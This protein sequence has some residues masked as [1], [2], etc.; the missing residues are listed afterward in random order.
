MMKKNTKHNS[1]FVILFAVTLAALLLSIALGVGTIAEKEVRF[2]TSAA[3][4]NHAFFAADTGIECALDNNKSGDIAFT[5]G[6]PGTISCLGGSIPLEGSSS[7][8]SFVLPGL[9]ATN[10]CA[11]VTVTKNP[12]FTTVVSKGYN[13]GN[14]LC[15]SAGG[16]RVERELRVVFSTITEEF[17][18]PIGWWTFDEGSGPTAFDSSDSGTND[19]SWNGSGTH[20]ASAL[21][22]YAGQFAAANNDYVYLN[23]PSSLQPTS[24]VTVAAWFQTSSPTQRIFRKRLYGYGLDMNGGRVSFNAYDI[25]KTNHSIT[26]SATYNDGEWHHAV[27]VYDGITVEL[28]IDGSPENSVLFSAPAGIYYEPGGIAIGKDGNGAS[29]QFTGL[30]DDVRLYDVPLTE[31]EVS[32][33]YDGTLH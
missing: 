24:A 10:A 8:W 23:D 21:G 12:P 7:P 17:I 27:G 6:G 3:A 11:T 4:T 16:N 33:L 29:G 14:D 19:G 31:T 18:H 2:R 15:E 9:G 22:G 5:D 25:A 20:Y 26:S 32:N 13:S 1:G 28:Y 30:I